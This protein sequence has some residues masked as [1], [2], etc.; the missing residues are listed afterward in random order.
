MVITQ[1]S[2]IILFME[3][4]LIN[5]HKTLMLHLAGWLMHTPV[6]SSFLQK[7]ILSMLICILM[8]P[9]Y[10]NSRFPM[11]RQNVLTISQ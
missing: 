5:T 7:H 9:Q 6:R 1:S 4:Q 11:T 2:E 8:Q 10:D 3:P